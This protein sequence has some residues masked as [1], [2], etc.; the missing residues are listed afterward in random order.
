[1]Q[2]ECCYFDELKQTTRDQR[3][4]EQ[5]TVM[6]VQY[7]LKGFVFPNKWTTVNSLLSPPPPPHPR[8]LFISSTFE[9]G[10]V[11]KRELIQFSKDD[12]ISTP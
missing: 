1:M 8:G 9:G 3:C 12:G 4:N 5:L 10:L 11:E 6:Q 2:H 7:Q